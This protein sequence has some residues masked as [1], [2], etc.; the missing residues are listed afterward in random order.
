MAFLLLH[1]YMDFISL[2]YHSLFIIIEVL[3]NTL[4]HLINIQLRE[5]NTLLVETKK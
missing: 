5:F 3:I 1:N 2:N 4:L